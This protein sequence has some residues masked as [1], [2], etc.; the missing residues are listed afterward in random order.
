MITTLRRPA[1][2]LA[3]AALALSLAACTNSAEDAGADAADGESTSEG[4]RTVDTKFGE[5][6]VPGDPQKVVA[7]GWGDAETALALGV[8]PIGAS[9]WL[10]FG[11]DDDGVGP[12]A[13]GLYDESPELFG[14]LELDTQ[15]VGALEPDLILDVRSSGDQDRYDALSKIA[16][17][18]GVPEGGDSYLTTTEQQVTMIAAALGKEELGQ[19]LLDGVDDAFA[20][21]REEH[22]E[23]DGL[24][25]TVSAYSSDGWGVYTEGDARVQFMENLGLTQS[26]DVA[27]IESDSFYVPVSNE[28]LDLLDA[29]VMVS[30]PIFV[31]A[32][33]ISKQRLYN[34]LPAVED[35]RAVLIDDL[36]L[37]N[38]F[39]IATTL[40]IEYAIDNVTPLLADAAAK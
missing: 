37:S 38:A 31:E 35:G 33:E 12:W 27:A 10:G 30:F 25:S 19:E 14:T 20:T 36:D 17:V 15:A 16:P 22:P 6:E 21:A 39:S 28:E 26:E 40:G 4:P 32:S 7:L 23:L 29:D 24:S 18:I 1:A 13:Q 34:A 2:A 11:E 5:I 8:Q 9:D 3:A